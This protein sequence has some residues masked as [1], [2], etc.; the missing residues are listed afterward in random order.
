MN[1][2]AEQ[3]VDHVPNERKGMMDIAPKGVLYYL[4]FPEEEPSKHDEVERFIA[5]I[6]EAAQQAYKQAH[7]ETGI[8]FPLGPHEKGHPHS[9][10]V[11]KRSKFKVLLPI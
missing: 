2:V 3:K 1:I 6:R 8:A 9:Y 4:E 7:L 11:V 10:V 5:S